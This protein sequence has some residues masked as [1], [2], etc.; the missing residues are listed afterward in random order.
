MIQYENALKNKIFG[1]FVGKFFHT[2]ISFTYAQ[3]SLQITCA[4]EICFNRN[5]RSCIRYSRLHIVIYRYRIKSMWKGFAI[6]R[7][8]TVK[9]VLTRAMF[10]FTRK[11]ARDRTVRE[12]TEHFRFRS[13]SVRLGHMEFHARAFLRS[14]IG[15]RSR[16][17]LNF[18][19]RFNLGIP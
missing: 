3:N 5:V 1:I 2:I 8:N 10:S 18:V 13:L 16:D 15:S 19:C 12:S 11:R 4:S 17:S 9:L 14:V 7:R 6:H